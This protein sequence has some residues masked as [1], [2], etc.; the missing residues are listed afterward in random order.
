MGNLFALVV[1]PLQAFAVSLVRPRSRRSSHCSLNFKL[2]A[3]FLTCCLTVR[4]CSC[5]SSVRWLHDSTRWRSVLAHVVVWRARCL[6][7]CFG[8]RF[9]VVP[10]SLDYVCLCLSAVSGFMVVQVAFACNGYLNCLGI[11]DVACIA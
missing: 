5:D 6:P 7:V 9:A 11:C 1:C 10:S 3:P 4:E 8:G 2:A